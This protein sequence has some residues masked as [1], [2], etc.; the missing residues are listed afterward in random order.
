MGRFIISPDGERF[1][2]W[3]S[4]V[5]AP[6]SL[7]YSKEKLIEVGTY[8]LGMDAS[9]WS[10]LRFERVLRNGT[11]EYGSAPVS[12]A[13]GF[14][15][16]VSVNRAGPNEECLTA[17]GLLALYSA[18]DEDVIFDPEFVA[19]D[20]VTLIEFDPSWGPEDVDQ[21]SDDA[22]GADWN[23]ETEPWPQGVIAVAKARVI[24]G[25]TEVA[26]VWLR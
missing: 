13:A 23:P 8:E 26:N 6:I 11:S 22:M 14:A 15:E 5:D 19:W 16:F 18:S 10:A 17:E 4:N 25:V 2:I 1:A 7:F 9:D 12:P 21:R 3:S 20:H 24:A